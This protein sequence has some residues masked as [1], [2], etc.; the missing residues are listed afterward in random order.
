MLFDFILLL[1]GL[2]LVLFSAEWFTNSVEFLGNRFNLSEAVVGSI[3][4][5]VGTALPETILPMVAI[6]VHGSRASHEIG[7]GAI[8]GAPFMLATL[9]FFITGFA[10]VIGCATGKRGLQLK[11]DLANT[12]KDLLFFLCA[13]S[14]AVFLPFAGVSNVVILVV[15]SFLYVVYV[16]VTLRIKSTATEVSK[17]L[18]LSSI[19]KR[20]KPLESSAVLGV[21]QLIVSL[22]VM[23]YGANEFVDGIERLSVVSGVNPM[24]FSLLVA[25]V[26]TELPEKFNSFVWTM[27]SKDTLAVGNITGAMVFQSTFPVAVGLLFTSWHLDSGTLLAAVIALF[28]SLVFFVILLVFRRINGVILSISGMLYLVYAVCV[29]L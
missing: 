4:A 29:F 9:G 3:L 26:A 23:V 15:L 17:D 7:I 16:A 8:V 28:S 2:L 18:I 5:A 20:F 10:A 25:P 6:L 11:L 14:L 27:R 13:F 21:I 19:L 22:S 12:K 1:V 24:V